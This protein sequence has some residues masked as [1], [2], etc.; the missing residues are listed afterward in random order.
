MHSV[1]YSKRSEMPEIKFIA[2]IIFDVTWVGLG[3][4]SL[5]NTFFASVDQFEKIVIFLMFIAMGIFR[6][7]KMHHSNEEKRLTNEQLKLD[8]KKQKREMDKSK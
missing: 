7:I 5:L 4:V 3:G 8:I 1:G 6:M 2:W